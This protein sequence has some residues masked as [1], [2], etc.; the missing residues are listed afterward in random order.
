MFIRKLAE[1]EPEPKQ[2]SRRKGALDRKDLAELEFMYR[3]RAVK[4]RL[5]D[6]IC[7]M[8]IMEERTIGPDSRS[9][10]C[11]WKNIWLNEKRLTWLKEVDALILSLNR[12]QSTVSYLLML[13]VGFT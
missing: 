12:I 10:L 2:K 3:L 5:L 6:F 4:Y 9:N 1:L 8:L 11:P 7:D 13:Q